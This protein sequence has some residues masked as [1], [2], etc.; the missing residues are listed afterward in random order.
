MVLESFLF[1][2]CDV[3]LFCSVVVA[4]ESF[5]FSSCGVVRIFSVQYLESFLF[6]SCYVIDSFLFSRAVAF[7]SY[8]FLLPMCDQTQHAR[9]YQTCSGSLSRTVGIVEVS[10][11]NLTHWST[12]TCSSL[13]TAIY[14]YYTILNFSSSWLS[15]CAS[16]NSS[17]W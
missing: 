2:G 17:D 6:S 9:L 8:L 12:C 3:S 11:L 1:S 14:M 15:I 16:T 5:L 4:L 10:S 7:L 13:C